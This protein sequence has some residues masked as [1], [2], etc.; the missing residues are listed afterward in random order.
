MST[1]SAKAP[2]KAGQAK[3][4]TKTTTV[5]KTTQPRQTLVTRGLGSKVQKPKT[6]ASGKKVVNSHSNQVLTNSGLMRFSRGRMFHRRALYRISKW[7]TAQAQLQANKTQKTAGSIQKK[8]ARTLALK[9]KP[10]GGDR[11]GKE[12]LVR[13][14]RFVKEKSNYDFLVILFVFVFF[15]YSHVTIQ[16]KNCQRNSQLNEKLSLVIH[17]TFDRHLH[18]VLLSF[19]LLVNMPEKYE[20]NQS[21]FFLHHFEI[22]LIFFLFQRVVIVRQLPSGLLLVS[23]NENNFV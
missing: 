12:R 18:P 8:K 10:V 11:N 5:V 1:P 7:K 16:P 19:L 15:F 13:T 9:K 4:T 6:T 14:K 2:T 17:V 22:N 23:G 20:F 21:F 3:T